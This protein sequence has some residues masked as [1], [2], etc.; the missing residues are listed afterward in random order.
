MA[1]PQARIVGPQKSQVA[2]PARPSLQ[3][4]KKS[5]L[6][7]G[8]GKIGGKKPAYPSKFLGKGKVTPQLKGSLARKAKQFLRKKKK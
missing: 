8:A 4:G 3:E 2:T 7:K 1:N 5:S 6:G